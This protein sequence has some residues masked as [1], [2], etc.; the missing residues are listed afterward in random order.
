MRRVYHN[1]MALPERLRV[2]LMS[3]AA[4]YIEMTRVMERDLGFDE[5]LR[6]VVSVA[7]L[8]GERIRAILRAGAA[9]AGPYRYRWTPLEIEAGGEEA[10]LAARLA[11]FPHAEPDRP[12]DPAR[13]LLARIRAGVET[14]ELP[15]E[16]AARRLFTE[17]RSFWD[18]LMER[19]AARIPR[20]ET[21]SHR[22][23]ADVYSYEP[24]P[25]DE[26]AL[27]GAASLLRAART[28]EQ[29]TGLPLEKVTLYV[30]R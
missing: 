10:D 30:K 14:I 12:F 29:V 19:S 25:E 22:E 2:K 16:A 20:Y 17:K 23:Q 7:G 27:R 1:P 18:V 24:T 21:F 8:D 3:D 6:M 4:G 11:R 9:V 5:L 28:A 15:R 13:C 26:Q